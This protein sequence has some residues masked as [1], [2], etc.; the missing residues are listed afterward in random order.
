MQI[1]FGKSQSRVMSDVEMVAARMSFALFHAS[2]RGEN[3][4]TLGCRMS[5]FLRGP[6]MITY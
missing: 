3:S 2:Q 1:A 5:A 6:T 4:A